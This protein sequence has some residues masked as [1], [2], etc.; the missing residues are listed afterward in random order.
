MT[1]ELA[2]IEELAVELARLA[3]AEIEMALGKTLS[4]RYKGEE[5]GGAS[6]QDPVSEIDQRVEQ[7][8]R[9]R[10]AERFPGHTIIG[11]EMGGG[12]G[13]GDW[14]WAIDPIDGT[15]NFINGFPLFAA[16][17][18]V[19]HKMQP[20]VGAVWCSTSHALRPGTYHAR[21]GGRLR[22]E[23]EE[24]AAVSR[25]GVRRPLVGE[26]EAGPSNEWDVRKTGSAALECA[27]VA[28]G[29]LRAARFDSPNLWDV[30]GGIPL[31]H[32]VGGGVR[33]FVESEWRSLDLF[34]EVSWRRPLA[35]G[36]ENLLASICKD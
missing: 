22:F 29:L 18:G 13:E 6:W 35:L 16:S 15:A 2:A 27:F 8:L 36:D 12:E 30:A 24:I 9:A 19:L 32:A 14:L 31:V 34:D 5:T 28:A 11:E 3:G 25:I 21:R 23:Q 17:I 33:E 10:L 7:I 20:V 26:P 4:I 1:E